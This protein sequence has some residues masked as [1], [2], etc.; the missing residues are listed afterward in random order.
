MNGNTARCLERVAR[1][2]GVRF[3]YGVLP[4]AFRMSSDYER[5]LKQIARLAGTSDTEWRRRTG[6]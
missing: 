3:H 4:R 5:S 1:L 2:L 6:E